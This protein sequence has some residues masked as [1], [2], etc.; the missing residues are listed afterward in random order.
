MLTFERANELFTYDHIK[1]SLVHKINYGNKIT[2]ENV[3][4]P[5]K[6]MCHRFTYWEYGTCTT[7]SV[8]RLCWLLMTGTFPSFRLTQA[9]GNKKNIKWDNIKRQTVF[10]GRLRQQGLVRYFCCGQSKAIIVEEKGNIISVRSFYASTG[11][12]PIQ[13]ENLNPIIDIDRKSFNKAYKKA[14]FVSIQ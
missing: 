8:T 14:G 13:K 10:G 12:F 6:N 2:G 3:G 7:Y 1:G 5:H 9:D 4:F 11:E